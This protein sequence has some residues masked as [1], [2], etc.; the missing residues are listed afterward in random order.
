MYKVDIPYRDYF[1]DDKEAVE[2]LYFNLTAFE[3]AEI[4][5]EFESEGGI[6]KYMTE[7]LQS[8]NYAN[9]FKVLKMLF[10]RGYGRRLETEGRSR[11]IKKPEW[12]AELLPS[13]EFEA[14]YL[15]LT[16]DTKFAE[17]FWHGL[18]NEE[19]LKKA[20]QVQEVEVLEKQQVS[21]G[22]NFR[23]LPLEEQV[24]L[25]QAKVAANEA[26]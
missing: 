16:S 2:T 13:P 25:L 21:G 5:V 6:Q 15:Q 11:F 14:F 9:A 26:K 23:D 20:Q 19:L 1:N 22:K 24:K 4:A 7:S 3:L 17:A 8:D 12:V 18:V 10:V